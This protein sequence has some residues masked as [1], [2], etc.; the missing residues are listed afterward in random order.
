M[1]RISLAVSTDLNHD[2]RMQR[3]AL[4]LQQA[5]YQV[6]LIGRTKS[7]SKPLPYTAYRSIRLVTLFER[8]ILFYVIF[9]IR[10]FLALVVRRSQAICA[11]D[12][13]TLPAAWLAA[14]LKGNMLFY[15]AHELFTEVPE[16]IDRPRIRSIWENIESFFLPKVDV[17]YTVNTSLANWYKNKYGIDFEVVRNMPYSCTPVKQNEVEFILY[18]G[19][20]NAGRGLECL[21]E[22]VKILNMPCILAG[23]GDLTED[24]KAKTSALNIAHLVTFV[25]MLSP[26]DLQKYTAKAWIGINLLEARSPNY[27]YSLANKFF[28]YV[29]AGKP[30]LSMAFPEYKLLQNEYEVS[31]L[32]EALDP[33]A[34]A[35][36]LLQLK[37]N[38][39]QY[40]LLVSNCQQAA[41]HWIWELEENK[42]LR[43]YA[44]L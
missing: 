5:G 27:Y 10:L 17:A 34:I 37:A 4:S 38:P 1:K 24:L 31:I 43:L 33:E 26:E 44:K 36:T 39:V 9:N 7:N 28:D 6:S 35:S 25:G 2:Q 30:Q 19:A 13:D 21:L 12:L 8:G 15:D 42:L 20:L 11:V 16:L 18:Q 29:Q 23:D 41:L 32:V 40:N 22:V 3:I 14:R